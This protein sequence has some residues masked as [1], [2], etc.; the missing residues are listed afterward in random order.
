MNKWF[1][2]ILD[3]ISVWTLTI[4]YIVGSL[5]IWIIYLIINRGRIKD[6]DYLDY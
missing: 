6:E 4:I 2:E 5:F 1:K 3:L